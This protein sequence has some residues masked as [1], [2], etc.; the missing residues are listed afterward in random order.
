MLTVLL[1]TTVSSVYGSDDDE[2]MF[3][4]SQ[5]QEPISISHMPPTAPLRTS[6]KHPST[7]KAT[8]TVNTASH[9]GT[10]TT[11]VDEQSDL[12]IRALE[13][14][15][16]Q[17]QAMLQSVATELAVLRMGTGGSLEGG[18]GSSGQ[19]GKPGPPTSQN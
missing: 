14:A 18:A 3:L 11:K 5:S 1:Y 15:F 12:R 8:P 13:Q 16:V 17:N 10:G 9:A 2:D 7:T 19:V 4:H 6:P